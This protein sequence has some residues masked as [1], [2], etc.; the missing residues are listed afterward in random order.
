MSVLMLWL[1]QFQHRLPLVCLF[2]CSL[3]RE[4][5]LDTVMIMARNVPAVLP[6]TLR[7]FEDCAYWVGFDWSTVPCRTRKRSILAWLP[8][9]SDRNSRWG[10]FVRV[11]S[12]GL[13]CLANLRKT[14]WLQHVMP[15]RASSCHCILASS[16]S[17]FSRP[18]LFAFAAVH[19]Y[20][21][22]CQVPC[23]LPERPCRL[24][25]QPLCCSSAGPAVLFDGFRL[26]FFL[27][28]LDH[29]VQHNLPSSA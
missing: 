7:L 12:S 20:Q 5:P 23:A 26:H 19:T 10:W 11:V 24:A 2:Q 29:C 9:P 18:V 22:V 6:P 3:L 21:W 28:S 16:P 1:C 8:I 13:Q 15:L 14:T 27:T 17:A 25:C 4:N